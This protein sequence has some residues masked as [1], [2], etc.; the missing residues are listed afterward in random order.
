MTGMSKRSGD[1]WFVYILGCGDGSL[2]TGSPRTLDQKTHPLRPGTVVVIPANV[3][4]SLE[5]D[6]GHELEFVIFGSPP[7]PIEDERAKPRKP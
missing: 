5:A 2:Y 1:K 4:H 6:P 7:I 3:L